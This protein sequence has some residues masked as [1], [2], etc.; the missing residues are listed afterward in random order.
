MAGPRRRDLDS[1]RGLGTLRLSR[2]AALLYAAVAGAGAVACER[3]P[4]PPAYPEPPTLPELP[5]SGNVRVSR[6][7]FTSHAEPNLAGQPARPP[8]PAR[9]LFP[10]PIRVISSTDRGQTWTQPAELGIGAMETRVR[11]DTNVP[12]LPAVVAHRRQPFAAAAFVVRLNPA[13]ASPTSRSASPTAA[14]DAGRHRDLCPAKTT[15]RSYTQP[16]LAIDENGRL[17]LS[18]FAHRRQ[19]VDVAVLLANPGDRSL[20]PAGGDHQPAVQP[21]AGR[22]GRQTR[23]LVDRR[24][25]RPRQRRRHCPPVLGRSPHRTPGNLHRTG[26]YQPKPHAH[27]NTNI[28]LD[29]EVI[30]LHWRG[31]GPDPRSEPPSS[32]SWQG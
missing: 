28:D 24:L 13:H 20:R 11:P 25:P 2:R 30:A 18:A 17:A 7:R 26:A 23:R 12:G 15:T 21:G 14:V 6:D 8:Q 19:L 31:G 5:S 3:S 9:R 10:A 29:T 1:T 32:V 22:E 16:Q 27:V 4:A